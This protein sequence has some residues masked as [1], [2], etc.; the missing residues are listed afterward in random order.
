MEFKDVIGRRRMT[1]S[2]LSRPLPE[3]ALDRI[4]GAALRAPSAGFTQGFDFVVFEG[5]EQTA[6]FWKHATD[7]AWRSRPSLPGLLN[8]PVVAVAVS[9]PGAYRARYAER[10]KAGSALYGVEEWPVPW[11]DVDTGFACLLML[12]AA[13]DEGLGAL[14][15][16]IPYRPDELIT[17]LGVPPGRRI[18]GAIAI[19]YPAA[20]DRPSPS[21]KRGRRSL[22]D[23]MHRGGW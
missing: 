14:L 15:F 18:L 1:R 7:P 23:V 20:D 8:A 16:G 21:V 9:D 11:W 13:V 5:P 22:D 19:G 2:F 12:L 10:D 17:S 3:G 4:L 6:R